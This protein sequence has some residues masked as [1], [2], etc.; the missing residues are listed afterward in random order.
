[1][2]KLITMVSVFLLGGCLTIDLPPADRHAEC[3]IQ[4][5]DRRID[6]NH[7]Y[8]MLSSGVSQQKL[9]PSPSDS[10]KSLI[11]S[12][13]FESNGEL[14]FEISDLS[15]TVSGFFVLTYVSEIRGSLRSG[16]EIIS[17]LRSGKVIESGQGH[18]PSGCS[19]ALTPAFHDLAKQIHE[20]ARGSG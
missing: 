3:S 1:M 7:I 13:G 10:L 15:C 18:T 14:V 8:V 11:C 5:L 20:A 4:V 17:E 2:R 9:S 16:T 12:N 6:R 19:S